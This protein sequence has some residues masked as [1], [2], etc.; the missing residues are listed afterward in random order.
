MMDKDGSIGKFHICSGTWYEELNEDGHIK[1]VYFSDEMRQILGYNNQEE[2]P[3]NL[4]VLL[5][6]I[7]PDDVDKMV[8][9]AVAA[10]TGESSGYDVEFRIRKKDGTYILV[11]ATGNLIRSTDGK[12]YM[13]HGAMIDIS[14][15]MEEGEGNT[16]LRKN[17]YYR[18]RQAESAQWFGIVHDIDQTARFRI[19]YTDNGEVA[20]ISWND[21]YWKML[22]YS[23]SIEFPATW[24]NWFNSILPEDQGLVLDAMEVLKHIADPMDVHEEEFRMYAKDRSVRHVHISVRRVFD[25]AGNPKQVLGMAKDISKQ[26]HLELHTRIFDIFSK[27]Y[28]SVNVINVIKH[29][30]RVIR[31]KNTRYTHQ[32]IENRIAGKSYENIMDEY[33]DNYVAPEDRERIHRITKIENLVMQVSSKEMYRIKFAQVDG[34]G[35]RHF[36]QGNYL[37][38]NDESGNP[39]I[40]AGFREITDIVIAEREKQEQFRAAKEAAEAANR[41]KTAF[42]FNMSHDIRTPMNAIMGYRDLLEKYQEDPSRREYY[43]LKMNEVSKVLLS[44][45]DNVLEMARIEKGT[46][47]MDEAVWDAY[48]FMD[49]LH[50]VFMP[51]MEKKGLIF[52]KDIHLKHSH[53]YCD[54]VKLRDVFLNI[55]TNAYKYTESGGR[56]NMSVEELPYDHDGWALYRTTISDTGIGIS[57]EFLPKLFDAFSREKNSIGNK[58]EGTG[59][60]MS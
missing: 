20:A 48:D 7:H 5:D 8:E 59:L 3:D 9:G 53:I 55:I 19:D 27:D 43:L 12:P 51:M 54:S 31:H 36:Y 6:H 24:P 2:F 50:S 40:V 17:L 34:N 35:Q 28:L 46:L 44:I 25:K 37:R 52:T 16:T 42:L 15:L 21:A 58:I 18:V 39:A 30:M 14:E 45:I 41:A 49:Y 29:T 33:I 38:L 13:M 47:E 10:S 60:G 26:K 56:V 23:S 22:G 4:Q 57:E 11:N 1:A 32:E